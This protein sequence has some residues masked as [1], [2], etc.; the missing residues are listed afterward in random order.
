MRMWRYSIWSR[1]ASRPIGPVGGSLSASSRTLPIA[2]AMSDVV[3]HHHLDLVPFLRL[4]FG[5]CLVRAGHQVIAALELR[6][7][8]ENPAVRV[9]CGAELDAQ[10]KV[11]RKLFGGPELPQPRPFAASCGWTVRTPSPGR[12]AAIGR[13]RFPLDHWFVQVMPAGEIRAI[14]ELT[15]PASGLQSSPGEPVERGTRARSGGRSFMARSFVRTSERGKG[16]GE[17]WGRARLRPIRAGKNLSWAKQKR[18]RLPGSACGCCNR[19]Q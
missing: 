5:E 19:A 15:K 4:V 2:G 1:S 3:L 16:K 8:E 11:L 18:C 17:G 6:L 14:E 7:A 9:D 12:I 10:D 13:F